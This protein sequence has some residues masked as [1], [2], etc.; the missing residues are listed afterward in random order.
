MPDEK[1]LDQRRAETVEAVDELLVQSGLKRAD[2][3]TTDVVIITTQRGFDGDSGTSLT[4]VLIPSDTCTAM[5][6]GML[7]MAQIEISAHA[8]GVYQQLNEA[9]DDEGE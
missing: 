6:V 5:V 9:V 4:T 8:A 3:L 2:M 1:T 7:G